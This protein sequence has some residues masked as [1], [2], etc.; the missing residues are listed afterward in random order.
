MDARQLIAGAEAGNIPDVAV[1]VGAELFFIERAVAALRRATVGDETHGFNDETFD[2]K[3]AVAARVI[4]A[5]RTLP[6]LAERRFVLVRD[7]DKMATAEFESLGGYLDGA[8]DTACLVLT[9]EKLDGRSRFAKR[10]KDLGYWVEATPLRASDLRAFVAGEAARR[11]LKL[12]PDALAAL[13]DAVGNDLS[14]IDDALERLS[15]YVGQGETITGDAV[16]ACVSRV[17]VETIWALVD[18]VGA[19]NRRAALEASGSLLGDGEPPLRVLSMIARQLRILG[20]MREA[21]RAGAAATDAAQRAGAPPF[22]ARELADAA[23][24][25]DDARLGRA[26]TLLAEVD[27]ALKGSRRPPDTVLEGAI[28]ELTR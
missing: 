8:C 22:K 5:A 7:V 23:R 18:A 11:K 19:R 4:E 15:L 26:F 9:A 12:T 27:V 13:L 21:L 28:L 3:G 17:R 25:F 6:M 16:D 2:G 1:V 10:A 20:R 14:G 24:R